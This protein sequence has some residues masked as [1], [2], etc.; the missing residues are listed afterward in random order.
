M[1]PVV[2]KSAERGGLLMAGSA[3]VIAIERKPAIVKEFAAKCYAFF[4]KGIVFEMVKRFG[5]DVRFF[6][7]YIMQVIGIVLFFAGVQSVGQANGKQGEYEYQLKAFFHAVVLMVTG[8]EF[9]PVAFDIGHAFFL[10]NP[11]LFGR[12]ADFC[13]DPHFLLY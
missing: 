8:P 13:G 12:T 4:G 3:G 9:F 6:L 1:A 2:F 7:G 11:F 5:K 10:V